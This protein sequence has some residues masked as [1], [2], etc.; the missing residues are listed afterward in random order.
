MNQR[1]ERLDKLAHIF[2]LQDKFDSELIKKRSLE[3]IQWEEW[4]QKE[5]LAIISEL[6]ELLNE[7]NFKWW[8]NPKDVNIDNVREELVDIFHFFISMCLKTGM[9]ADDLYQGYIDKNKENF[10]RQNGKSLKEGYKWE[11][12]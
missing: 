11:A 6:G 1:G 3:N 8:K 4:I 7:I 12:K 10:D 9:K 5:A 2:E